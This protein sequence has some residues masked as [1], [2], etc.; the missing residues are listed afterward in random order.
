MVSRKKKL[1]SYDHENWY[2]IKKLQ[3]QIYIS[4]TFVVVVAFYDTLQQHCMCQRDKEKESDVWEQV[5]LLLLLFVTLHFMIKFRV[6]PYLFIYIAEH[7]TSKLKFLQ[8]LSLSLFLTLWFTNFHAL[9]PSSSTTLCFAYVNIVRMF[10]ERYVYL[11][12]FLSVDYAIHKYL[13]DYIMFLKRKLKHW[14]IQQNTHKWEA[15]LR[16]FHVISTKT[17]FDFESNSL[18][19]LI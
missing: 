5:L 12:Q 15:I 2:V 11:E 19:L 3:Q 8:V 14:K 6:S 13:N 7:S 10:R 4:C 17:N 9:S 18:L 1:H 16:W